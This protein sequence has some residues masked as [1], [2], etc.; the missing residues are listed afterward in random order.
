M[1]LHECYLIVIHLEIATCN[2]DTVFYLFYLC[3]IDTNAMGFLSYGV[4]RVP[5]RLVCISPLC[6]FVF[7][8]YGGQCPYFL[9][10]FTFLITHQWARCRTYSLV[11]TL[12]S[13]EGEQIK[14]EILLTIR[15]NSILCIIFIESG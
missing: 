14:Y 8:D 7:L 15:K 10:R 3:F 5:V 2:T 4:F 13:Y 11:V 6:V 12:I 9:D 1:S